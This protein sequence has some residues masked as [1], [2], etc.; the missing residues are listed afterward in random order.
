MAS[1]TTRDYYQVLGVP[2]TASDKDIR[3]AYRRLAR[4][5]HPDLNPGDKA[6]ESR[7]KELQTAY[8]VLSD[9]KKRPKYDQFGANWE[10]VER[11]QSAGGFPNRPTGRTRPDFG[12]GGDFSDIFDGIFG[13]LGGTGTRSRA[14]FRT[15][16]RAGEDVEHPVDVSLDEAY[17]GT[18]RILEF[19]PRAG[20]PRKLEVRIPAGVK[21]GARIRLAGEGE[22]GTGGGAAGDLYL[23]VTVRPHGTY[24]R[25]E[26]DLT[27]DIAVPLTTAVLGG[28]VQVPTFKGKFVLRIPPETQNGQTFRMA[29]LGMPKT[30][31]GFG[32]LFVRAKVT[33]PTRLTPEERQLFEEF[34]R[35]RNAG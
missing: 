13:G 26:D 11:A 30:G 5:Y 20:T 3:S 28:E 18:S 25:K 17:L 23:V 21:S 8:D 24:E 31:G 34:Q 32:D 6:A 29:G 16:S 19:P 14:G 1:S 12:E 35:L 33:L 10:N 2:R 4:K 7:F 9:P 15:R 22:P 27:S